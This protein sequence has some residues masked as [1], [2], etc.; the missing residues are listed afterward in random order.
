MVWVALLSRVTFEEF[1]TVIWV[2]VQW[3]EVEV[4][5]WI[6]IELVMGC[7]IFV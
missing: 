5:G 7:S 6:V 1:K 4:E 3:V 2:I